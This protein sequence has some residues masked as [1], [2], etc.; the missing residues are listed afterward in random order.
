VRDDYPRPP[1]SQGRR[2]PAVPRCWGRRLAGLQDLAPGPVGY[3]RLAPLRVESRSRLHLLIER[4][5]PPQLREVWSERHR[6]QL[7]LDV[8]LLACEGWAALGRIPKD[9]LPGLRKARFDPDRIKEVEA[10]V[11]HDVIAF[12]TVVGESVGQ[13]EARY[14]HVGLTSSDVIDT[15]FALQLR[16]SADLILADLQKLRQAAA[17]LA[18][19]HRRT[20]M[21]GRTHGV[22]AE[23]I[24]FGFKVAG[25]VAELDRARDRLGAAREEVSAGKL[26]GAVGTYGTVDPRVEE[27]VCRQLGLRTDPAATQVLSRDRH[28]SFMAALAVA[29]ASLER[30]AL[31]IRHLQ[32]TEV[33]EALEPFGE[34]QKGSSAM[35]HKR[36]PVL[37]E[38]VCGLARVVRGYAG[39]ALENVALWH[40]RDISHSSAERVIFP[41]ACCLLGY[42]AQTMTVVVAGLEVHPERMARNLELG[43]GV[44]YS[45]RV[46]LALVEAGLAREDA[47]RLVQAAA[48]KALADEGSFRQ[49]LQGDP[50]VARRLEG[51][52]DQLFDPQA[53]LEHVDLVFERLGLLKRAEVK[54]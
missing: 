14:L 26:S 10:R 25:W 31:E 28:A 42:M 23:P 21:A 7:W 40:E 51:R 38:R 36:N 3:N 12:L 19:R 32:R 44:V 53:G 18:L 49:L 6:F 52:W 22:H 8:E 34:E 46:L 45:Q 30:I 11:G 1:R 24:T 29:A 37:C 48:M 43:G 17:E 47:Y 39:T 16:E 35:P 41:D 5:S 15:A 4:Y 50:D 33:G 20:P 54:K 27:H 2:R 13:P 9:A